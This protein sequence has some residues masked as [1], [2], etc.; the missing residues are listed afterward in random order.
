MERER[1][2][3][4]DALE[5]GGRERGRETVRSYIDIDI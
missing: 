4:R 2:R 3:A 5:E 1:K